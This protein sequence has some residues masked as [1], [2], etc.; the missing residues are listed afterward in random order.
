LL[1]IHFYSVVLDGVYEDRGDDEPRFHP[2]PPPDD[3][4]IARIARRVA[5][6]FKQRGLGP[7]DESPSSDPLG[8]ESW[9]AALAAA[10]MQGRIAIG[11]QAGQRL[12]KLGDRVDPEDPPAR[13][14]PLCANIAGLGHV[15]RRGAVSGRPS[16]PRVR[17]HL[18]AA[19][20]CAS[21][22]GS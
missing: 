5:H 16:A 7:D 11:P 10:S 13:S 6:R 3:R 20:V 12:L 8:E 14:S 15:D 4:E 18:A 9:L 19:A 21:M 1:N 17:V 2:L 22:G